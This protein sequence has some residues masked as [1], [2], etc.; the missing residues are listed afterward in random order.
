VM[1]LGLIRAQALVLNYVVRNE[2]VLHQLL[3]PRQA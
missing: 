1:I 2:R 3:V